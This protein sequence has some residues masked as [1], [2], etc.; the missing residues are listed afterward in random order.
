MSRRVE[1]FFRVMEVE[2]ERPPPQT[3]AGLG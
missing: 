2:M 3:G 1:I